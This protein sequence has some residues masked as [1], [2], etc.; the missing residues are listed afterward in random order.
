MMPLV[1][2]LNRSS[3]WWHIEASFRGVLGIIVGFQLYCV[4]N[5]LDV[6]TS[7]Y[8]MKFISY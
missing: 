3:S 7:F 1:V 6:W 4:Q 2:L 5:F 8:T